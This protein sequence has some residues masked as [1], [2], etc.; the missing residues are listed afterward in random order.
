MAYKEYQVQQDVATDQECR[1]PHT[2]TLKTDSNVSPTF[3]YAKLIHDCAT[4]V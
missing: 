4:R 3:V 2:Q 1:G